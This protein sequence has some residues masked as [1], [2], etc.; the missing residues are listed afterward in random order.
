MKKGLTCA[1][2]AA[3]ML[4]ILGA[5]VVTAQAVSADGNYPPIIQKLV[6]R[7]GLNIEEVR[8]VF[9]EARA[10]R[11]QNMQVRFEES[12]EERLNKAV[13]QGKLTQEQK[14]AILAKQEEMQERYEGLRELSPEE[15]RA[16][17]QE[18]REEMQ[19]WA[20]ENGVDLRFM[21]GL[22]AGG[23]AGGFPGM[24]RMPKGPG[25]GFGPTW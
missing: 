14:E 2:A 3:A 5:A 23:F 19:A 9:D 21:C 4:G 18:T 12:F 6:E 15:R 16:K 10:E 25:R 22:R 17:M 1:L 8:E 24:P 20:E 13:E 11:R 7:F